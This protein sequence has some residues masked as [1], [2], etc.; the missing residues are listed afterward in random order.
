M[1][2]MCVA[3]ECDRQQRHAEGDGGIRAPL[4]RVHDRSAGLPRPNDGQVQQPDGEAVQQHGRHVRQEQ[5]D[6]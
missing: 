3:G 4:R 2:E 6:R 5:R 1:F